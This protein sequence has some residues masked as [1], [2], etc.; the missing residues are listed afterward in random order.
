MYTVLYTQDM[1][2]NKLVPKVT[3][4]SKLDS[5]ELA[6]LVYGKNKSLSKGAIAELANRSKFLAQKAKEVKA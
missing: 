1:A 6:A 4:L 5:F 3:D 2:N